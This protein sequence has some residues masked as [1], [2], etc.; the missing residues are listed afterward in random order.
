VSEALDLTH[1]FNCPTCAL[2]VP[3]GFAFC[4]RCRA[5]AEGRAYDASE[6]RAHERQYVFSL[7]V[8]TLGALAIPRL[9]RSDGFTSGEK[10]G[11]GLL[12]VL[13][14]AAVVVVL[15]VFARYFPE[16]LRSLTQR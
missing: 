8:L 3:G 12:G 5:K 10:A 16:Y 9:M 14:T 13:N 11:L 15:L 7:V 2:S 6:T 1:P 4:P